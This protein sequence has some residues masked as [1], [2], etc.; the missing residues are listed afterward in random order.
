MRQLMIGL[1]I[2]SL[3]HVAGANVIAQ[4]PQPREEIHKEL[5]EQ[6][7]KLDA[8]LQ[9][10]V[11]D[12]LKAVREAEK[13]AIE[14]LKALA[15]AE[16]GSG[17]IREATEAWTEVIKLDSTDPEANKFFRAIGREDIVQQQ[18]AKAIEEQSPE[19][20]MRVQWQSESGSVYRRQANGIWTHSWQDKDGLHQRAYVEVG[21]TPCFIELFHD[22]GHF[23]QHKRIYGDRLFWRYANEKDWIDQT[24][25]QWTN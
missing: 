2:A 4:D 16:A 12:H 19:P 13:A 9:G 25:G 3:V 22:A 18:I 11:D 6:K 15:R 23:K 7:K 20:S 5:E 14:E 21:R 8:I 10:I 17:K 24:K 1:V